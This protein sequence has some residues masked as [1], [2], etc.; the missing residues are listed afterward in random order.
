MVLF[1][2]L[3]LADAEAEQLTEPS[4]GQSSQSTRMIAHKSTR[5]AQRR[6][7]LAQRLLER[8]PKESDMDVLDNSSEHTES[9]P[10]DEEKLSFEEFR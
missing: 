9:D 4:Q 3:A 8:I 2:L 7:L 6:R 1:D 10:E 5:P